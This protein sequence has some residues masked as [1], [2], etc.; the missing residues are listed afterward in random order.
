MNP[1]VRVSPL[2]IDCAK[3]SG[4]YPKER[5]ASSTFFAMRAETSGCP[6]STRETLEIATPALR[7]TSSMVATGRGVTRSSGFLFDMA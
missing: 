3:I 7:A 5:V 2:R 6:E 1:I 4:S